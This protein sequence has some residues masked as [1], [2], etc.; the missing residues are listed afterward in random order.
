MS[1]AA[2]PGPSARIDLAAIRHS[3]GVLAERAPGAALMAVVKADGYGHGMAQATGAALAAGATWLGVATAAEALEVR[4]AGFTTPLLAWLF[5]PGTA[6]APLLAA[7]VDIG[8]SSRAQ[9]AEVAAAARETGLPARVHVKLDTGLFRNGVTAEDLPEFVAALGPLVAE[10][11][12]ELVGVMSHLAFADAPGHPTI[13]AQ[14]DA[15]LAGV[16]SFERAGLPPQ[17]R[18]LANSAATLLRPDLHFDLV[19][20]GLAV[21]G[22]T[23]VPQVGGFGLRPAMTLRSPLAHVKSAPAGVGVSY[24]HTY[25]T[26]APT[27][28]ALVPLGY[29]DGVPRSAGN[30][31]PVAVA[32]RRFRIAGRVCMDQFVLDVGTEVGAGLQAGD[33]AVLFGPGDDGE[34][35]AQ[36]WADLLDTIS[37]EIVTRVGARVPREYLGESV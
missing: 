1:N 10:R 22:L 33:E 20:P 9:L 30:C 37:Y 18:H 8:V 32:G 11:A 17:L 21:Y 27:T 25:T 23:P 35:T 31:A 28:L 14:R 5:T 3:V 4:A 36:E 7:G 12:V 24:G 34:P 19:R 6:Y 29:G 26:P 16:G 13:D 15:F 2:A